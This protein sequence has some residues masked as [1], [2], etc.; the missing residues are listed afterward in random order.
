[1][2]HRVQK[3]QGGWERETGIMQCWWKKSS[4]KLRLYNIANF[5]ELH[6]KIQKPVF[7]EIKHSKYIFQNL[8]SDYLRMAGFQ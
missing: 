6:P 5:Y 8:N 1:M 7:T 2:L 4:Y 3:K